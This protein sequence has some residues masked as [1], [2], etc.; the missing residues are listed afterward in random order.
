[1][2]KARD[3]THDFVLARQVL[4][5]QVDKYFNN[6]ITFRFLRLTVLK[7]STGREF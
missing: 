4:G 2:G 7:N 3:Q 5:L 1:M 6:E